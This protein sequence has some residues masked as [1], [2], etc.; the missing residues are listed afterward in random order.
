MTTVSL[1][2]PRIRKF[3]QLFVKKRLNDAIHVGDE[4]A[5]DGRL[6]GVMWVTEGLRLYREKE[7]RLEQFL[8][9]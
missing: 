8:G 7:M 4:R 2:R 6:G 3:L 5:E 1:H 9:R